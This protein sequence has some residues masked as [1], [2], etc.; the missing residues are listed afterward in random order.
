MRFHIIRKVLVA[1]L[2]IAPVFTY[3]DC[4]KQSKCGCE[5]DVLFSMAETHATFYFNETG[6]ILY[7]QTLTDP[8]SKYNFCNPSEMFAKL[9]GFKSGDV[10]QVSGEAFWDCNY[11]YQSSNSSYQN[12]Y[13]IYV[14]QGTDITV[15]L[16]GKK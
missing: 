16:Y 5:G 13:K 7:F 9:T 12:P 10:L 1:F 14:V 3:S 2:I 15:N 8:Y 4:K 6:T 11:I